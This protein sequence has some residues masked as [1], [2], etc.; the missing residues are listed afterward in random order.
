MA[1][2][3]TEPTVLLVNLSGRGDKDLGHVMAVLA[4]QKAAEQKNSE[5]QTAAKLAAAQQQQ[6]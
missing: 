5:Q 6:Q 1:E 3:A 4:E 2:A